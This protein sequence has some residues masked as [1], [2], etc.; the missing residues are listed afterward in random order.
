MAFVFIHHTQQTDAMLIGKAVDLK[1]L[2][3]TW[4]DLLLEFQGGIHQFV[5]LKRRRVEVRLKVGLAVGGQALQTG[6]DGFQLSSRA[7]I[8][9]HISRLGVGERTGLGCCFLQLFDQFNQHNVLVQRW[10]RGEGLPT[11]GTAEDIIIISV[12]EASDTLHTVT[13]TTGDGHWD[14]Q[15]VQAYRTRERVWVF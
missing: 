12:P 7:G 15:S 11:L 10:S 14:F 4:T 6:L 3:V 2:I 8:T 1:Q 5:L 9:L 13:M